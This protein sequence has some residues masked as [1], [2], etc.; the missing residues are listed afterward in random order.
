MPISGDRVY[1]VAMACAWVPIRQQ[2]YCGSVCVPCCRDD[3]GTTC[4]S[5]QERHSKLHLVVTV[6][7]VSR[8]DQL[9]VDA[10]P[11]M[12]LPFMSLSCNAV[13]LPTAQA[14]HVTCVFASSLFCQDQIECVDWVKSRLQH[15]HLNLGRWINVRCCPSA[16][17]PSEKQLERRCACS[18]SSLCLRVEYW[19]QQQEK[20]VLSGWSGTLTNT[21]TVGI[22][23]FHDHLELVFLH[24][25]TAFLHALGQLIGR[26]QAIASSIQRQKLSPQT[27]YL[28]F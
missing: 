23:G 13:R 2:S 8:L 28:M 12:W 17:P 15:F 11:S 14:K 4:F 22:Q 3:S 19:M 20:S 27:L 25:V 18:D 9:P 7:V 5:H 24:R 10:N 1:L 6:H 21:G 26:Q 16:R